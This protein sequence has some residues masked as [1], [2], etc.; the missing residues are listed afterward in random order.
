MR[1]CTI[2]GCTKQHR[3]KGLCST[4]YNQA[5]QPR[6][7][8]LSPVACAACGEVI[9]R[10]AHA[11]RRHVC[12]TRCRAA[13]QFGPSSSGPG[14]WSWTDMAMRR[15]RRLGATIVEPV[16]RL[17]VFERDAWTCY[18]CDQVLERDADPFDVLSATVDHVIALRHGGPH[19]MSNVRCACLGCNSRKQD[20][21]AA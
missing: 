12:S 1:T 16:A 7:H 2:P 4:H 8:A 6:R 11:D 15:A 13:L 9:W 10:K 3:A 19:T 18:L 5:H 21:I 20:R 17:E 14:P